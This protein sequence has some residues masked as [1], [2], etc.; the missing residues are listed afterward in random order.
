MQLTDLSTSKSYGGKMY[1]RI[2]K[3]SNIYYEYFWYL[4][5]HGLPTVDNPLGYPLSQIMTPKWLL[6]EYP[7]GCECF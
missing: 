2:Y 1:E 6:D 3:M 5:W 7:S 4:V